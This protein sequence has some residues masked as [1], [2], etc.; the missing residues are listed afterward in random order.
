LEAVFTH[1]I[2]G[3]PPGA[4]AWL[5]EGERVCVDGGWVDEAVPG[6]GAV[7]GAPVLL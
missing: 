3:P 2:P 1:T 4:G 6:A 5:A 7:E